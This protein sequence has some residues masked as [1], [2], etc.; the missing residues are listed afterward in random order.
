MMSKMMSN[1]FKEALDYGDLRRLKTVMGG[2][3]KSLGKAEGLGYY[4]VVDTNK[5][6]KRAVWDENG[7]CIL[8]SEGSTADFDLILL[9]TEIDWR[10]MPAG[11][12]AKA[13]LNGKQESLYFCR[14]DEEGNAF[15]YTGGRDH[16]TGCGAAIA[17]PVKLL[18]GDWV[19]YDAKERGGEC[20]VDPNVKVL[21]RTVEL[22][23]LGDGFFMEKGEDALPAD[24]YYWSSGIESEIIAY[25]IVEQVV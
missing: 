14:S 11:V 17:Q 22:S 8:S 9:K 5:G 18:D 20:P 25:K 6:V 16:R 23:D 21:V 13:N 19:C 1:E 15:F 7:K 4:G 2:N 12:L 24:H 3:L 10:K